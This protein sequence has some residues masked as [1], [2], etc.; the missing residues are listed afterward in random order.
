MSRNQDVLLEHSYQVVTWD[1]FHNRHKFGGGGVTNDHIAR[2]DYIRANCMDPAEK[3]SW[4]IYDPHDHGDEGLMLIGEN[5][6][7]LCDEAVRHLEL[8]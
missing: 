1:E 6:Q 8:N 3:N 5:L 4:V 7:E 2:A